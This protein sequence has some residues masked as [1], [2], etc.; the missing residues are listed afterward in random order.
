MNCNSS[1]SFTLIKAV[2]GFINYK[3]AEGLTQRSIDSYERILDKW[4]IH[5][6]D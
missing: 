1:G 4:V 5:T 6:G 2:A 3:T